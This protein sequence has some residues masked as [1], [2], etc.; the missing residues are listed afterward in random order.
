MKIFRI[1]LA[2]IILVAGGFLAYNH[3]SWDVYA[4]EKFQAP[5]EGFQQVSISQLKKNPAD[6]RDK[7][8]EIQGTI[9]LECPTGC[10]FYMKDETG[11]DIKVELA[12]DNFAI[13][14]AAGKKARVQGKF[15]IENDQ[16]QVNGKKVFIK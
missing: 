15:V 14:Q 10:W 12:Y 16:P 9:S 7:M 11:A 5:Q 4:S 13:P 8:V 3:F 6:Y 1:F 2:I